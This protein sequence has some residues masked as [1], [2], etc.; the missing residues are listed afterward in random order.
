MSD[1]TEALEIELDGWDLNL[2][3]DEDAFTIT[4]SGA[5]G[6][7]IGVSMDRELAEE[8]AQELHQLLGLGDDED[9]ED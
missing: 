3:D 9:D 7:K 6:E 2:D 1:D 5:D 8:L 4:L